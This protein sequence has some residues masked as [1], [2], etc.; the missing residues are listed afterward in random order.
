[1]YPK[2]II[3]PKKYAYN[4]DFLTNLCHK[5]N[6]SVMAVSKVFCKDPRLL[7]VLE[8]SN[9]DYI[10]DSKLEN[11]MN[12]KTKK[13]K[14]Y[15]RI[16]AMSEA[17]LVVR[18]TD[19]SLNSEL[20]VIYKLNE[21]AAKMKKRHQI[22]LMVDLGDLRE[23]IYYDQFDLSDV[24]KIYQL[25]H[26]DLIGIGTNLTCYG[27][28]IPTIETYR[29]L[30]EIKDQ[31]ES[32]F[33]IKLEIISGGN[34]SSI[35]MLLAFELPK[36][37]NNLRIGEAMILGRETAYQKRIDHLYEDVI[38]LKTE[39][40]EIKDKPSYPEGVLGFDAFGNKRD[41]VDKGMIKRAIL[42]I[43]RQDIDF[44]DLL[45]IKG[46]NFMGSSSDHLIIEIEDGQYKIGDILT[47]KLKY[48]AIL[49]LMTS[50]YV[51]KEYV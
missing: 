49:S 6:L 43:G 17:S 20:D 46:I 33:K 3:D 10:A 19:I 5:N 38:V 32:H 22:I 2:V 16:P 18:Y 15:L 45:P 36:F 9:I 35:P 8:Q 51:E 4:V 11:I 39:I 25:S 44:N 47:F 27:S 48:G 28:V 21:V 14:V 23:G 29:K 40:L 7:D 41:Y 31:I 13:T 34:S 37:I 50:P 30:K 12:M 1:M 26:I 42:G 24:E